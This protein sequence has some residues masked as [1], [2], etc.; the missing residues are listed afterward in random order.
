[1][2]YFLFTLALLI[3]HVCMAQVDYG[4]PNNEPL[5]EILTGK[6]RSI[7]VMHFPKKNDPIKI[8][9]KFYWKHITSIVYKEGD[10]T[11]IEYGAYIFYNNQW[12]LR[13]SYP[14]TELDE[15]FG[16]IDQRMEQAQPY[17]FINNWRVDSSLFGGWAL[18]YFIGKT[19][20]GE[21]VCGY[22][23]IHTTSNLLN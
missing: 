5:P 18:W 4:T 1:M 10:I 14:L 9:D 13:R 22:E 15:T 16:T 19:G 17:T 8:D 11:I 3:V 2:K 23:T 7:E 20:S 21:I 12:N 6:R